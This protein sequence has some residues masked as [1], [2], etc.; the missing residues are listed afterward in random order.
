MTPLQ[1]MTLSGEKATQSNFAIPSLVIPYPLLFKCM[2]N[3]YAVNCRMILIF[4]FYLKGYTIVL[5]P[6]SP[7]QDMLRG[8]HV[9]LGNTPI[10][11]SG[12]TLEWC[13]ISLL[14]V[15]NKIYWRDLFSVPTSL[16]NK[17]VQIGSELLLLFLSRMA[18]PLSKSGYDEGILW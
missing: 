7:N 14:I 5:I 18:F 2:F 9:Y 12:N 13:P 15:C 10:L 16:L 4:F 17:L 6:R 1:H 3:N 8:S 11:M